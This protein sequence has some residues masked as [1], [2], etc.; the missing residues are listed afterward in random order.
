MRLARLG[1]SR[2]GELLV[3]RLPFAPYDSF[4]YLASGLTLSGAETARQL[5]AIIRA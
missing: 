5:P 3:D 2:R 4:G 1:R